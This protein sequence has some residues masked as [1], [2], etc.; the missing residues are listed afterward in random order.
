MPSANGDDA[1]ES[2]GSDEGR[3]GGRGSPASAAGDAGAGE[4]ARKQARRKITA[5]PGTGGH[6]WFFI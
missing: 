6:E 1:T 3:Y 2:H 5:G 4:Q